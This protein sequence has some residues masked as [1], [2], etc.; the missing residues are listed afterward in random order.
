MSVTFLVG[1]ITLIAMYATLTLALD[2]QFSYGSLINLGIVAYVAVGAYT[3]SIV[4]QVPASPFDDY[5]F[6]FEQPIWVGLLAAA[7]AGLAFGALT[8]WPSLRLRGEYLALMTF[9]FAE[10]FDS[11]LINAK[12]VSNGLVGLPSVLRPFEDMDPDMQI[13]GFAGLTVA[14][15]ALTFL[16]VRR[17]VT[18]PYGRVVL[19]VSDDE[20]GAAAIGKNIGITR[21]QTFLIGSV[22]MSITGAFFVMYVSLAVPTIFTPEVTFTVW[23]ALVLGG[24][25]NRWGAVLGAT[26]LIGMQEGLRLL[27][28]PP[29]QSA[30]I[31]SLRLFLTGLLLVVLLR[32]RPPE[33]LVRTAARTRRRWRKDPGGATQPGAEAA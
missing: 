16:L 24:I 12:S 5:K 17:V 18:S 27:S 4:T 29:D 19:A 14:L 10:V 6:G 11:F 2:L 21:M 26:L 25:R 23:I 7:L 20:K 22:I 30:F 32:I 3:Y 31:S 9:A 8:G 33:H 13:W 1:V 28:L 15:A